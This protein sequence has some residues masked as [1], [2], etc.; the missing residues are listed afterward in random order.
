[1]IWN[2]GK[3]IAKAP[4][5]DKYGLIRKECKRNFPLMTNSVIVNT[6]III[7]Y[8]VRLLNAVGAIKLTA[9]PPSQPPSAIAR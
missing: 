1:M 9:N 4:N 5:V 7:G 2:N 3:A 6:P 8:S